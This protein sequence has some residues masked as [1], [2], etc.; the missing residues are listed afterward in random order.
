MRA[1]AICQGDNTCDAR[2]PH[3]CYN[4]L[5]VAAMDAPWATPS[6]ES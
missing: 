3:V 1:P 5:D 6:D 2:V 4:G